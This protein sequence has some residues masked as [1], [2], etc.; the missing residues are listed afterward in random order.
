M[1][2]RPL[3]TFGCAVMIMCGASP[4]M[5][6]CP[7]Q[8]CPAAFANLGFDGDTFNN[9]VAP[10]WSS[11]T[12]G[13]VTFRRRVGGNFQGGVAQGI[14]AANGWAQKSYLFQSGQVCAGT[15]Y[16]IKV[17]AGWS[18]A[19]ANGT[20]WT[21]SLGVAQGHQTDWSAMTHQAQLWPFG[22]AAATNTAALRVIALGG[23][24]TVM[25]KIEQAWSSTWI[26]DMSITVVGAATIPPTA[27]HT[28]TPTSVNTKTP[29]P[30][31][32]PQL[33][34][35][36][37][38]NSGFEGAFSNGVA[39]G[40][41]GFAAAAGGY[42][43]QN[44]LLGRIGGG[45]Y[46]F[47]PNWPTNMDDENVRMSAK[48]YLVD[49]SRFNMVKRLREEL[50][51]DTLIVAKTDAETLFPNGD[52]YSNPTLNGRYMADW[53][54]A[55][56]VADGFFAHAYYGVNEPDMN[57]VPNLIKAAQFELAY[58]R[59]LHQLG[60][61]SVVLNHAFGTPANL[62]NMLIPEVRDLLAE[63][64]YVGYHPY[65]DPRYNRTC[66]PRGFDIVMRYTQIR[67]LYDQRGWRVPPAI[68][69][70]GGV[71]VIVENGSPNPQEARDDMVCYEALLRTQDRMAI[72]LNYFVTA[73]WG[74]WAG[75]DITR[76]P[77]I[78]DGI[79]A[80]N[81]AN[82][83][84]ARTGLRAQQV[85]GKREPFDR[86]VAQAVN[87]QPG[88]TYI[89][90]LWAQYTFYDG[91]P[92][93]W[94]SSAVIRV[95]WDPSGQT[96]NPDAPSVQWSGNLVGGTLVETDIWYR[97]QATVIAGGPQGSLW[98]R[99]AQ[100]QALPSVRVSFDDVSLRQ[101]LTSAPVGFPLL[102][103]Y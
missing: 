19:T 33:G 39:S 17:T 52:P 98:L 4:W 2:L 34:P 83:Y 15:E 7:A 55:R 10:G 21:S 91:Y 14:D 49:L 11:S 58:T 60:L 67:A 50:G 95:G 99:A 94:P 27:T 73:S 16:E 13:G 71:H 12:D 103:A 5:P 62:N 81:R 22:T 96:A 85:G 6:Q 59:R 44:A 38:T 40:W 72:G 75:Y 47:M 68:Y 78:I 25:I 80:A 26:D 66:D 42:H 65:A 76:Y 37:L 102:N 89:I 31:L 18:P 3:A 100:A 35:N 24:L 1:I 41:T 8:T 36:L 9:G 46:G 43:K 53:W 79:R 74:G 63:A 57:H 30:T 77:L 20:R 28:L 97:F 29:T 61:R 86:G 23:V 45:I 90:E 69:T 54:A 84:D 70:E 48:T 87:T 82:P 92:N 88:A 51:D 64:D 93:A 32:P 101:S 56:S